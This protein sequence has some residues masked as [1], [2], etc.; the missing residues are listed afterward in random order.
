MQ[1][2]AGSHDRWQNI[3]Q[4]DDVLGAARNGSRA[5]LAELYR[6]HGDAVHTLAY[7]ITGSREDAED[8]LQDVFI[9]LPRALGS[10]DERGRFDGWLKRVVARTCVMRLRAASRRR[11]QPLDDVAGLAVSGE[12]S[13][14]VVERLALQRALAR[15]APRLRAVFMLREVEGYS[16]AEIAGLLKISP[17]ASATRLTRAWSLLRRELT[18]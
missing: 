11:E 17:G 8:V 6:V 2:S 1:G 9:G 5:A 13:A 3:G 4:P 7:R 10:Y 14:N 12:A 18:S 16:H 15:L